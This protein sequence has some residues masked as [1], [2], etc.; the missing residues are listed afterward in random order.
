[1]SV[2]LATPRAGVFVEE[3]K[4]LLC[5]ATP[6]EVLLLALSFGPSAPGQ[7]GE[8]SIL[9]TQLAVATD[10]VHMLK[11]ACTPLGR[12]FMCGRDGN[13]YELVYQA[14]DTGRFPLPTAPLVDTGTRFQRKIQKRNVS[15]SVLSSLIPSFLKLTT[16]DP[17]VDIACS[18]SYIV[19]IA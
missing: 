9:P 16:G 11:F 1:M 13:L 7:V 2:G 14:E 19:L 4:Y 6:L 17:I 10:Q 18:A 12:I 15:G 5:I 8:M 3:V